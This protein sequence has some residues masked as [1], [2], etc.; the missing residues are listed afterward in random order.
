MRHP[1]R[2]KPLKP[3]SVG[4]RTLAAM[5]EQRRALADDKTRFTNR[6][7]DTLKQYYPQ[8]LEW[9][10]HRD[11]ILFCDFLTR[12]PTQMHAKKTRKSVLEAFFKVHNLRSATLIATRIEAIKASKPLTQDVA[13]ITPYRY[14]HWCWSSRYALRCRPL[15]G[16]TRRLQ[17]SHRHCRTIC[18]SVTCLVPVKLWRHG[19]S[20]PL[21]NSVNAMQRPMNCKCIQVLRRS[22]KAA[23]R[24][25]GYIGGCGVQS[26][27]GKRL[28]NGLR[29][30]L[31][32]LFGQALFT[33]SSEERAALIKLPCAHWHSSGFGSFS[34]AGK[35]AHLMM[36]P[37]T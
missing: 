34:V 27:Y 30:P 35:I 20:P 29:K 14:W 33:S 8:A 6:L 12:W 13:V 7:G 2:F 9:L 25:T 26:L 17:H 16:L 4:M 37:G 11:T 15:T 32:N 36:N 22:L 1:E 5:V 21:V 19:C 31:I 28:L 3:Q 18:F 24:K 10:D 23:V